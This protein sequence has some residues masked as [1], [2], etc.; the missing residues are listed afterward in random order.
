[1]LSDLER[2]KLFEEIKVMPGH[3]TKL[4]KIIDIIASSS[5]DLTNLSG[6]SQDLEPASFYQ[7][8]SQDAFM[9]ELDS[10]D[11][12]EKQLERVLN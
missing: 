8:N 12:Y 9:S 3:A 2:D 1:M 4:L 6:Y 11:D 10:M 5:K 7:K